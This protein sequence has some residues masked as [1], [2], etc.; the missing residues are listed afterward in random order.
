[1]EEE[2]NINLNTS[3]EEDEKP[4]KLVEGVKLVVGI[5]VEYVADKVI[6][7]ILDL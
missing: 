3:V 7:S 6:D 5:T 2:E 1:M 4:N